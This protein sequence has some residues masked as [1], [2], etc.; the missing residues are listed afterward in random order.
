MNIQEVVQVGGLPFCWI[1][2]LVVHGR[3]RSLPRLFPGPIFF[4]WY[5]GDVLYPFP[6]LGWR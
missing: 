3:G 5:A 4:W 6:K 1:C 2:R